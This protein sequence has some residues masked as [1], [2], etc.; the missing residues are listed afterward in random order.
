MPPR[1]YF[2]IAIVLIVT[3]VQDTA[4]S[5]QH[6]PFPRKVWSF[7]DKGFESAPLMDKLCFENKRRVA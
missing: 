4:S 1:L 7:W 6:F 5:E 2:N 3:L